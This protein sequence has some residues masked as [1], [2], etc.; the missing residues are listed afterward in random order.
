MIIDRVSSGL[1]T[2]VA[3]VGV[4]ADRVPSELRADISSTTDRRYGKVT[5]LDNSAWRRRAL[6][7]DLEHA[8][9][10]QDLIVESIPAIRVEDQQ[11]LGIHDPGAIYDDLRFRD[12]IARGGI[13][14]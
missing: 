11:A 9:D 12:T 6:F 3:G 14:Q 5:R 7:V 1:R 10:P 4:S 8:A 13:N 2:D